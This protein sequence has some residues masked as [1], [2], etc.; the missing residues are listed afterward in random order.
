MFDD[1]SNHTIDNQ[2]APCS[3]DTSYRASSRMVRSADRARTPPRQ[4]ADVLSGRP[5]VPPRVTRHFMF[6]GGAANGIVLSCLVS[7]SDRAYREET[8]LA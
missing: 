6:S 1:E 5:S 2:P 8:V 4:T 7:Q 3:S